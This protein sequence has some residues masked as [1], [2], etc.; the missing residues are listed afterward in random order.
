MMMLFSQESECTGASSGWCFSG[1][2]VEEGCNPAELKRASKV[3]HFLTST[4]LILPL[5]HLLFV[6]L[7]Y[8]SQTENICEDRR[9]LILGI[10]LPF[11]SSVCL[12]RNRKERIVWRN[13]DSSRQ[14]CKFS[15]VYLNIH[16]G[17]KYNSELVL[18]T[19]RSRKREMYPVQIISDTRQPVYIF[20][21]PLLT[22]HL[23]V[24]V[25]LILLG[26]K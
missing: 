1:S 17:F 11:F 25:F 21:F 20:T 3:L 9:S 8:S 24:A 2:A 26:C 5:L 18:S 22:Q 15:L 13:I 14:L 16:I 19:A 10:K 7:F 4:F 12:E 6:H 23:A